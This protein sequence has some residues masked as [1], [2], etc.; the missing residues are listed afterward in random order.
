MIPRCGRV[1]RE[2]YHGWGTRTLSCRSP[3]RIRPQLLPGS[4]ALTQLAVL[5]GRRANSARSAS[6]SPS[7]RRPASR[8]A[9]RTQFQIACAVGSNSRDSSSGVRPDRTSSTIWRRNFR[10]VWRVTL[11]HR[12]TSSSSGKVST[13]PGQLHSVFGPEPPEEEPLDDLAQPVLGLLSQ[14]EG[15]A[16]N[17][18]QCVQGGPRSRSMAV[19]LPAPVPRAGPGGHSGPV[20]RRSG[21]KG[22]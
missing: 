13:K 5:T 3:V 8:S 20:D 22:A 11:R 7:S 1:I 19:K 18:L 17:W 6:G 14:E 4:H 15:R 16:G 2:A 21:L 10:R 12:N 9:W